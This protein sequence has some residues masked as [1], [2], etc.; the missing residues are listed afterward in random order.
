M[1]TQTQLKLIMP[2]A[3]EELTAKY[4]SAIV[5][6]CAEVHIDT[7]LRLAHFLTQIGHETG[8]MHAVTENLNYSANALLA[9]WPSLFN[10]ANVSSYEHKPEAIAN[11]AYG[12]RYGN[13]PED[14]GDGWRY[15]GRGFI[16]TTFKGN[17][18]TYQNFSNVDVV[19][20]PDL[21][22]I[23]PLHCVGSSTYFWSSHHINIFADRD[24]LKTLRKIVNGGQIGLDDCAR[25][26]ANAKKVLGI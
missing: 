9:T 26:L 3:T 19:S 12:G 4:Y 24:D 23:D 13:G 2:A 25:R 15:R 1:I 6:R 22:V 16:Q 21:L 7:P 5:D 8:D 17:Y 11:R 14:T 20:N 10:E 18:I